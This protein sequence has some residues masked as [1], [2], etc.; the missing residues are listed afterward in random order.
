M[1]T[2]ILLFYYNRPNMVKNALQ[3]LVDT[4]SGDWECAFIDDAS[5]LPGKEVVEEFLKD[6]PDVLAK[7]NFH[8]IHDTK[9]AKLE[10]GGSVF[11]SVANDIMR[12]SDADLCIMLCDDDAL[13]PT[14][15][16]GLHSY[17]TA[18]PDVQYAHS[19]LISFVPTE[20]DFAEVKKRQI[21]DCHLNYAHDINPF[22]M[23]DSSQVAWR[24][25]CV[26]EGGVEFPSPR[27]VAL[28]AVLYG[29]LF[30]KYG[31]CKYTGLIGQFKGWGVHQL[32]RHGGYDRKD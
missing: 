24:L 14:Y 16:E 2:L 1:K 25:S 6:R 27:T 20:E 29:Q 15:I 5:E 7:F 8:Y 13:F 4:T 23:V 26:K 18:N 22:S 28:D 9:E 21:A 12:R 32:G 10:R 11:G 3:S 31:P 17:F 30:N 19:H